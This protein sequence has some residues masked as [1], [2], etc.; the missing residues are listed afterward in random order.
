MT[1]RYVNRIGPNGVCARAVGLVL[2]L[3]LSSCQQT[4]SFEGTIEPEE[5]AVHKG[6]LPRLIVRSETK[7]PVIDQNNGDASAGRLRLVDL[8][9]ITKVSA[10]SQ[11]L[12]ADDLRA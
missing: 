9:V 10:G 1:H 2:C 8:A 5:N 6:Y 3:L 11:S 12:D 7:S 4:S